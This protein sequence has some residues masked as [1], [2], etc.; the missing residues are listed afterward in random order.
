MATVENLSCEN[1]NTELHFQ[2]PDLKAGNYKLILRSPEYGVAKNALNLTYKLKLTDILP[3]GIGTGGGS[4]LTMK[5]QGFGD[6]L[7]ISATLCGS[8]LG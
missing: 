1:A 6:G 5:G 3:T 8:Q 7:E 4:V 2:I